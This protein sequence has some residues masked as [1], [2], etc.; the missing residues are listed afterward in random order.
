[1]TNSRPERQDRPPLERGRDSGAGGQSPGL[2][3]IPGP[4]AV[5]AR[6]GASGKVCPP[7]PAQIAPFVQIL[8][9]DLAALFRLA[10]WW[11]GTLPFG[12]PARGQS[13]LRSG[14]T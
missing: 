4:G 5:N 12:K 3:P 13:A 7:V 1:M 14:R 2:A 6:S 9:T 8:G 11:R 10:F